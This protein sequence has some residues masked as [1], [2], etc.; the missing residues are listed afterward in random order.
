MNIDLSEFKINK[1]PI[2]EFIDKN[3]NHLFVK[4][5]SKNPSGSIKDRVFLYGLKKLL[6]LVILLKEHPQEM[7]QYL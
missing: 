3:N 5:E 1:T 7:L 2:A 4:E 6:N